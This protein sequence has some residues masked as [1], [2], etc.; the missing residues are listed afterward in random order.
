MEAIIFPDIYT[1]RKIFYHF[2][3][4]VIDSKAAE[5]GRITHNNSHYAI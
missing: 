5:F 1:T 2:N 4:R 3:V